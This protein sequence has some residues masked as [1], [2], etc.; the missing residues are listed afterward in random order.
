MSIGAKILLA[1]VLVVAGV[2]GVGGFFPQIIDP[3]W[4][5]AGPARRAASTGQASVSAPGKASA[6]EL[7]QSNSAG[8]PVAEAATSPTLTANAEAKANGL[9]VDPLVAAA[10]KSSKPTEEARGAIAKK[11]VVRV[12]RRRRG[13]SSYV[14]N[15]PGWGAWSGGSSGL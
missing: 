3:E 5:Q 2:I 12:E 1:A 13:Y 9:P 8:E 11:K 4:V 14:Q 10:V 7:S 15:S 6:P